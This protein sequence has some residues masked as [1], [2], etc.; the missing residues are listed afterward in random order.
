MLDDSAP[1]PIESTENHNPTPEPA[2]EPAAV[3]PPSVSMADREVSRPML[4]AAI[5]PLLGMVA[6]QGPNLWKEWKS[7]QVDRAAMKA[8][9][10]VDYIGIS[11]APQYAEPPKNWM[12]DEAD[13]TLL[14]S[15]WDRSMG[16]NT[17]FISGKADLDHSLLVGP[18][19]RD[20]QRA[21][22]RPI[23][24]IN[25]GVRWERLPDE[26][27]VVRLGLGDSMTVYPMAVLQKVLIIN[28]QLAKHSVAVIYTASTETDGYVNVYDAAVGSSRLTFGTSG[29]IYNKHPLLYDRSTESLWLCDGESMRALSGHFK[30]TSLSR[31]ARPD[32]ETWSSCRSEHPRMRLVIGADRSEKLSALR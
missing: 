32:V 18:Q 21:I 10:L 23:V 29:Y 14:W 3:T 31:R 7:L 13:K 15:G 6:W 11:P 9:A 25:R 5:I 4:V 8:S 17:W 16:H 19:G 12:H 20:V 1:R 27:P 28:D 2:L 24:E 30:G 22:D 26:A